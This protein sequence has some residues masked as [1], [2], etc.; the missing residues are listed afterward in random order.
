VVQTRDLCLS[1]F[2]CL[3]LTGIAFSLIWLF[4]S[5]CRP[6]QILLVLPSSQ[7]DFPLNVTLSSAVGP[8]SPFSRA[9]LHLF[10]LSS[11][12]R[13]R[14][15]SLAA[16]P[17]SLLWIDPPFRIWRLECVFTWP[18]RWRFPR[19]AILLTSHPN[20]PARLLIPY[21]VHRTWGDHGAYVNTTSPFD[22]LPSRFEPCH[23]SDFGPGKKVKSSVPLTSL[24]LN[25]RNS[26]AFPC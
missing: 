17:P 22:S 19:R 18:T 20:F 24:V 1:V 16:R 7:L 15:N 23:L 9:S 21:F 25:S 12:G 10:P 6:D 8:N 26:R 13:V 11:H 3:L 5:F 4:Q 2:S 14:E